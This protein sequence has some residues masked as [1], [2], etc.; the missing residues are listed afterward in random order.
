MLRYYPR[1]NISFPDNQ[2]PP[3]NMPLV[4]WSNC[5]EFVN[6]GYLRNE[7]V[8]ISINS[9]FPEKLVLDLRRAYFSSVSW[10]DS[11]VGRVL[12]ELQTLDLADNTVVSLVGDHGWQLGEHGEWCKS[13]NFELSTRV[14]MMLHIPVV[15]DKGIVSEQVAELVDLFPTITDAVGLC[16]LCVEGLRLLPMISNPNKPLKAAAFS[17]H[18]RHVNSTATAMG[19]SIRTQRYRYTEWVK[20]SDGPL[21]ETDWSVLFGVELYDHQ[22]DPDEIINRAHYES[23][24]EV[25]HTLSKQLRDGWRQSVHTLPD[26]QYP[27]HNMPLVAWSNCYEF[28]NF[29]Y[30]RNENVTIS[31][32]STFPEKLVLD[33]RRAYF[34]SVSWVDSLVGRVLT[35]LQTLGLADNTVVSLVGDHGWQLGEHGEWCK[36]TNF[37][38]ST[39]VPMMLHIPGVTNNGIVSEQIAELVDLFPTI[40]DAVGLG[41]LSTCPENS[42]KIELCAEGV[43]LLPMIS[44]PNKPLKK[45]A[46][47]L[48]RR[49][50]NSTATAM[51]YSIRTQQYRYTE[52]VKFSDGPLFE[53]DWSVLFGVELY[54]HGTDPDENINKA[55]YES[56][57]EVRHTLS[58]QLRDGWRQSVYAVSG[59]TGMEGRMDNGLVLLG[60]LITLSIIKTE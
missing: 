35:E 14:P 22:T 48:H 6:L 59:V 52:W 16:E 10:I 46:F 29:G 18:R 5:H 38:L 25:R 7:N 13:T 1:E 60:L 23:Y 8:T 53:T 31:I 30:L 11:L 12:T 17:L 26:N 20:F 4:A 19:Y 3:H 45:A 41:P 24:R 44:N 56:Y 42:S 47:S 37:E 15:T 34:S 27:P 51:G 55:H 21:F 9:T 2:Y 28:V 43:S 33:L 39:R 36:S 57:R 54:D 32:N 40:T 58:K 49:Q 50:V